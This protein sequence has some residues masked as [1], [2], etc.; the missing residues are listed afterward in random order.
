MLMTAYK[1]LVRKRAT[2]SIAKL[3]EIICPTAL[4]NHRTCTGEFEAFR[5][6]IKAWLLSLQEPKFFLPSNL[7]KNPNLFWLQ[8]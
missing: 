5:L 3:M 2:G 8:L 4:A 1:A 6:T 7:G